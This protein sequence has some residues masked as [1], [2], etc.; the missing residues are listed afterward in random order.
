LSC[1]AA[2]PLHHRCYV[3]RDIVGGEAII[4]GMLHIM[5]D[6]GGAQQRLGRDTA[7]VEADAAQQ[8]ALDDGDLQAKLRSPDRRDIA[9]GAGTEH[10]E[11][12]G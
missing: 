7:P 10:D 2:R 11:I 9:A 3:R 1:D 5:V 8:F 12:I 6:F 4:L